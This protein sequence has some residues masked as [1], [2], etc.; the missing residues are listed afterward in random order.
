MDPK[1]EFQKVWKDVAASAREFAALGLSYSSKALE[2]AGAKIKKAEETLKVQA[3]K[4]A[5]K[6]DVAPSEP[7]KTDAPA[8]APENDSK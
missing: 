6:D 5:D 3:V 2:V 1:A 7:V 4:L 8:A